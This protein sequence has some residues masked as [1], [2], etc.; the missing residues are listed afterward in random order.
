MNRHGVWALVSGFLMAS[1]LVAVPV[2]AVS[3]DPSS[4]V[5]PLPG[6]AVRRLIC[7]Q[8]VGLARYLRGL[9]AV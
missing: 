5:V 2:S 8:R 7:C 4:G 3:P 1:V 6:G 9:L